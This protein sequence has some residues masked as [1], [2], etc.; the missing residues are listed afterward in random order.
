MTAPHPDALKLANPRHAGRIPKHINA[1]QL[2]RIRHSAYT[3]PQ[4]VK[5][6]D[7]VD[8]DA[9]GLEDH[10]FADFGDEAAIL[11]HRNE[12]GGADFA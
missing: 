1:A 2:A 12:L 4:V 6:A 9:A 11:G 3:L 7:F 8:D 5:P 10:P